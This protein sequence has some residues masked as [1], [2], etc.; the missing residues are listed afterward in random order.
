MRHSIVVKFLMILLT[1]CSLVAAVAGGAGIVAM[2]GAELYVNG[3]EELRERECTSIATSIANAYVQNYV[4]KTLGSV[5]YPLLQSRYPDPNNRGDA[6]HWTVKLQLGDQILE[7]SGVDKKYTHVK[8][9]ELAPLF[10]VVTTYSPE[11]KPQE[12]TDP[13]G[14]TAST[15]GGA[16][17]APLDDTEVPDGYLYYDQET[18]WVGNGFQTYYVYY[19]QAPEYTVTV[20]MDDEVLESSALQIL[21]MM[22]PYRYGFIFILAACILL[23]AAGAVFLCWSAGQTKEGTVRPGGLNRIPLDVYALTAGIGSVVLLALFIKLVEWVNREGP[24]PGNLSLLGVNLLAIALLD[25]GFSFAF[26]AQIKAKNR[27]WWRHSVIGF[28]LG[29]LWLGIR[30]TARAAHKLFCLLPVIWQ[31][32]LTALAMVVAV[33]IAFLAAFGNSYIRANGIFVVWLL[34]T[35][36]ACGGVVL[37]G[38]YAFGLLI[39]GAKKMSQGELSHK[40]PT[41]YLVGSFR[42][43]AEKLNTLSDAATI[44]AEKQMHSERMKTELITNVSHDIKTPLTSIINFVDLLQKPH[45]QEQQEEYLDVLS[46]QSNRMKRLIEDLVDLSKAN[47]GNMPVNLVQ[48]DAV[49]TVN[50][51]LGE[52]ADKLEAANLTP[53]FRKP[54][55]PISICADGKLVWRVMSN[56]LSNAVKYAL[57]GTRL[58]VDLLQ[59]ESSVYLSV[60]NVSREELTATAEEL[61]ERFV[62][63]DASRNTEGSGLGLNIAQSLMEVQKGRLELSVDGDLFKVTL[64]FPGVSRS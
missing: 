36:A 1:A 59:I 7:D 33:G 56:L 39:S 21:T 28:C 11:D 19:Y 6:E 25:I 31:W 2:E 60:K 50:Q 15:Q 9:Y 3:L 46:R 17:R 13:T 12:P 24:H 44:L 20:Y 32:L 48:M 51:V 42:E 43:F 45:T 22:F 5:P 58:Y 30:F 62:R 4:A 38:A 54:E 26:V 64:V 27:Y 61:M 55:Q 47:T 34:L 18:S 37:Y 41:K 49:E 29:K 40:I 53:V 14:T 8:K 52:F 35:L 57:P 23:F 63:G 10:P 16:R